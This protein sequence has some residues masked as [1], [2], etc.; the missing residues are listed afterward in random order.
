MYDRGITHEVRLR[1]WAE[2]VREQKASGQS[3]KVWCET[4]GIPR[5]QYF[6]WQ[7]KLREAACM[8]AGREMEVAKAPEGWALCVAPAEPV[9]PEASSALTSSEQLCIEIGGMRVLVGCNYPE[10]KL[11]RLLR[12]LVTTC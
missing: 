6:Y 1:H 5:H 9:S 3:I 12:E 8:L 2:V 4:E 11:S 10:E 7:R